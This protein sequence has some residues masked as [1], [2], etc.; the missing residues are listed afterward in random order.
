MSKN[1][2]LAPIV[3][4]LVGIPQE[5]LGVL[6]DTINKVGSTDG[7]LWRTRFAKV[8]REGLKSSV[9]EVPKPKI[10][11]RPLYVGEETIIGPT[12][13]TRTIAQ[14]EDVF[15]GYIDSDFVNWGLDVS[16]PVT[17]AMKADIREM[18]EVNGTL[19]EIYGSLGRPLD[20]LC[21]RNQHQIILFCK[22]HKDKLQQD[23]DGTLFLFK[24]G[25]EFF[26]AAVYVSSSGR[27]R[28]SARRLSYDGVWDAADR[29]RFVIPQ[30]EPL[31]A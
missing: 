13:G 8:L 16:G 2:M 20:Q 22:E 4:A 1:D 10:Y 27:L 28:V 5:R 25:D 17:P 26:V 23:G 24:R 31:A 19:M 21:V 12:D 9:V 29:L 11:L 30:L 3:R 15:A 6:L 18:A 14:A 7:E